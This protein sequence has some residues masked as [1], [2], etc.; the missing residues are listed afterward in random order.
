MLQLSDALITE[1]NPAS[2]VSES[3]RSLR[4]YI[5]QQV[6]GT[7]DL[8]TALLVASPGHGEGKT[9][10]LA[11]VAVSFAQEGRKIAIVD[12]D[13]RRPAIHEVFGMENTSGLSSYL[14][15][16]ASSKD[17][18]RKVDSSLY[19]IL[20]ENSIYNAADMLGSAKMKQLID[21]L[22]EEYDLILIDSPSALDYTDARL[23][24]PITDGVVLVAQH[25]RTKR[26]DIRKTK[27]LMDQAGASIVGIV[28]NQVK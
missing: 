2:H 11:N 28:L 26:S 16:S 15:S 12:A 21:E 25:S 9:T 19:V 17:I 23:L 1:T 27:Q 8:G 7:S 24:A 20:A 4:T 13:L 14:R 5:R 18:I 3:F 10:L 22:R 6:I